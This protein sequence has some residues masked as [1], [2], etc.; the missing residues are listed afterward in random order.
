[1][2]MAWYIEPEKVDYSPTVSYINPIALR[3]AKTL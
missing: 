3:M 2:E 1:M